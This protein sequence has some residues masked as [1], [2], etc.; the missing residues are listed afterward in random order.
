M[1]VVYHISFMKLNASVVF[2]CRESSTK[3]E[4]NA[5]AR[6]DTAGAGL[7]EF[8]LQEMV[9][10]SKVHS[11]ALWIHKIKFAIADQP[12]FFLHASLLEIKVL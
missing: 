2:S 5:A 4:K 8:P 11:A 6:H 3:V 9:S 7:Q 10:R 1:N 12:V